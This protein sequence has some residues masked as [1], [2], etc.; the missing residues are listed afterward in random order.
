MHLWF[1]R[2]IPESADAN[3]HQTES[4]M[5]D[6]DV[7][8]ALCAISAVADFPALELAEKVRAFGKDYIFLFST[9]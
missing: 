8:T 6:D 7:A 3:I 4:W 2:K 5:L 9:T 1:E